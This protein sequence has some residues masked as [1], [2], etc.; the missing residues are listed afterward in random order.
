MCIHC[1][2]HH[3][4]VAEILSFATFDV[5]PWHETHVK[6]TERE[7]EREGVCV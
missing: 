3:S 6:T 7:G 4:R 2:R 1:G 5:S